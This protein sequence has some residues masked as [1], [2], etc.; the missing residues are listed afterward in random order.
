MIIPFNEIFLIFILVDTLNVLFEVVQTWP[1]F[2]LCFALLGCTLIGLV[3]Q[4]N[5]MD[6][7]LVPVQIIG[8][9]KAVGSITVRNVAPERFVVSEHVFPN[10]T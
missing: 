7:L 3:A 5:L 2:C 9:G 10:H 1:H 8:G 4:S 6:T